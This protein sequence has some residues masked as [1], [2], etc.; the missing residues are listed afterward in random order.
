M[1]PR[2]SR[3]L[4][5][6]FLG[7]TALDL[8]GRLGLTRAPGA[9]WPGRSMDGEAALVDDLRVLQDEH[10]AGL[11]VT[12]LERHELARLGNL[13]REAR[14]LSLAWLHHPIPDMRPPASPRA[15]FPVVD[16]LLADLGAGRTAVVH[17]WAGLGRTGTVAAC[18]LVAR[19]RRAAQ[20]VAQV[21]AVRPGAVQTAE[22]EAF[23]TEFEI[24]WLERAVRSAARPR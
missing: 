6:D 20:A 7:A 18:L 4:T 3:D 16:R 5:V 1:L 19:G 22:Q 10:G 8:P 2:M 17:C 24:A 23:V 11:L 12:L 21:R 13:K 14:R 15:L 9:W